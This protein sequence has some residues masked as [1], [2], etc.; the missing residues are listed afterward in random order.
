[1]ENEKTVTYG[2]YSYHFKPSYLNEDLTAGTY[3]YTLNKHIDA[4]PSA[5]PPTAEVK[6][7][8]RFD[9]V[10]ATGAATRVSAFRPYFTSNVTSSAKKMIPEHITFGS[11]DGEEGPETALDGDLEI[12]AR[13]RTIYTRSH[14]KEPV[15]IRIINVGGATL[16]SYVLEPEQTIETPIHVAGAYLVNR[17][18]LFIR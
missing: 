16:R 9:K 3:S 8:S 18:K 4:N 7:G 15:V 10:P 11:S 14:L 12:F 1:M 17:K 5:V 2:G 6:A 13:G